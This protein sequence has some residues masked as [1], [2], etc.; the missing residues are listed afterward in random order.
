[1]V[2][3]VACGHTE[4]AALEVQTSRGPAAAPVAPDVPVGRDEYV[5]AEPM[6][7]PGQKDS[8][9]VIPLGKSEGQG[10]LI[11]GLRV[12]VG[13]RRLWS[14]AEVTTPPLLSGAR[15]PAWMGGG[16]VFWNTKSLYTSS[17]FDG[18]LTPLVSLRETI[19]GVSFASS[20]ML[21]RSRSGERWYLDPR[22]GVPVR[23]P[24]A[25]MVDIAGLS[26]GRVAALGEFGR[27]F[28]SADHGAHF[29]EV[30]VRS[31]RAITEL[32][33]V[34]SESA[35]PRGAGEKGLW[36]LAEGGGAA[37]LDA[38]A[39]FT[40]FDKAPPADTASVRPPRPEWKGTDAPIR[41]AL[42]YG[43]P[44]DEGTAIVLSGGAVTK[45][46]LYSGEPVTVSA[47]R[48]PPDATC[49]AL[50]A[51]RDVVFACDRTAP[52]TSSKGAAGGGSFVASRALGDKGPIIER[53]F[54]TSAPF[55][56]GDDGSL[57]YG[58]PCAGTRV[59][60]DVVCVRGTSGGWQEYDL[61][62]MPKDQG[63]PFTV[64]RWIPRADGSALGIVGAPKPGIIDA[65][66]GEFR[67]WPAGETLP[68]SLASRAATGPKKRG[69]SR[70]TSQ[71]IDRSW[72]VT[73]GG[74]LRGWVDSGSVDVTP[75]GH[76]EPSPFA[77]DK[78]AA[79]GSFALAHSKDGR[80][81]QTVDH[82]LSWIETG[83]P[84][85]I[86]P[87]RAE[88]RFCSAV[89]CD[90]GTFYRIGWVPSSPQSSPPPRSAAAA[91]NVKTP[92]LPSVTCRVNAGPRAQ[93]V[94]RSESSP[95]DL[96]LGAVRLPKSDSDRGLEYVRIPYGHPAAQP[97]HESDFAPGSDDASLRAMFTGYEVGPG[98]A[99]ATVSGPNKDI[100]ALRR[101][102]AFVAP[103][104]VTAAVRRASFTVGEMMAHART[105]GI[106]LNDFLQED[107]TSVSW[108]A[109]VL[110]S[111]AAGPSDVVFAGSQG[112]LG[113]LR[114]GAAARARVTLRASSSEE[115]HVVSAVNLG[116][117][118]MALLELDS[119]GRGRVLKWAAATSTVNPLFE[120][121]GQSTAATYP[122]NPDAL[123]R[124][125]APN[126][127]AVVRTASGGTPPSE[128]DPALLVALGQ[129]VRPSALAPW[130]TL[131]PAD[132]PAC[133]SEVGGHRAVVQTFRPW[134]RLQGPSFHSDDDAP[135]MV[136]VRWTKTRVCLEAVEVKAGTMAYTM[137]DDN[138]RTAARSTTTYSGEAE[139]VVIARF[140][141]ATQANAVRAAIVAGAEV[142]QELVCA[143][144]R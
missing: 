62:S 37:R 17:A 26:D 105:A 48:L 103:F 112:L 30:N 4:H 8:T 115:R 142:R 14:A 123:A 120:V 32:R 86:K 28:V 55:Y 80:V 81:W 88:P 74:H 97:P 135:S 141:G 56:A 57:A 52:G 46:D 59:A 40:E 75:E 51:E 139:S 102:V 129:T 29:K 13:P 33:V 31:R 65:R 10:V 92:E 91:P 89:G 125:P 66:T 53:T 19:D 138:S 111:D 95:D 16:F 96:G 118:D 143:F 83:A 131:T 140:G 107:P 49:E 39:N 5:V 87:E 77:F 21:V 78:I 23:M 100:L 24:V 117:E 54:A 73:G 27:A 90:L 116:G 58:G 76:V 11:D 70:D 133:K 7:R 44:V 106:G 61:S 101:Q 137:K 22:T 2:G 94:A 72:T 108:L 35:S 64:G 6:G 68:T 60:A 45:I 119:D 93:T 67:P 124:G 132:D 9:V 34:T 38:G 99:R 114:G 82:G 104:D 12:V 41:L 130:S 144:D 122:A 98:D 136:R 110:S 36:L 43:V 109:P 18:P 85:A 63:G 3:L 84:P 15:I 71:L 1:V 47:G 127:L 79:Q 20:A 50:R 25:A 121:P 42:R 126:E 128:G 134:V 113:V 69:A